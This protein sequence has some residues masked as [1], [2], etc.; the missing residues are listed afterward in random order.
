MTFPNAFSFFKIFQGNFC[1]IQEQCFALTQA[2]TK[3][4]LI[5]TDLEHIILF[6]MWHKI[7]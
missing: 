6:R 7:C 5:I 4:G 1:F 2:R 3:Q